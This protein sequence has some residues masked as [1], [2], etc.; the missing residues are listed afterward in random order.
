VIYLASPYSHPE[1]AIREQRFRDACHAAASLMR[2][3][4][5]VFSPIAHGHPLTRHGIPGDWSFW[6]RHA[7]WYLE[8]CDEVV[9]LTLDGWEQ[10]VGVR[11]ELDLATTSHK[12]IWYWA[13]PDSSVM[14]IQGDDRDHAT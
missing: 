13:G 14:A 12:P 7:H 11:A 2:L 6:E 10:S 9:V 4:Q 1:Q 3:G 8:R 5:Q